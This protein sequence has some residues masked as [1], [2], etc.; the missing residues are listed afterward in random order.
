MDLVAQEK[1]LENGHDIEIVDSRQDSVGVFEPRNGRGVAQEI[2]ARVRAVHKQQCVERA[3]QESLEQQ[4]VEHVFNVLRQ[5]V[6]H[7]N[8]GVFEHEII[9]DSLRDGQR[10]GHIVERCV[11]GRF[12]DVVDF[13]ET[14]ALFF[15]GEL[16]VCVGVPKVALAHEGICGEGLIA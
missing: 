14:F 11:V 8:R 1:L 7:R 13:G 6:N 3:Q 5:L 2:I 15:V 12:V 4:I 16:I 10:D 9:F